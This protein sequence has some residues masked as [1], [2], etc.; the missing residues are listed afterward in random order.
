[1]CA[2]V[3]VVFAVIAE[4]LVPSVVAP[5]TVVAGAGVDG[6]IALT[7]VNDVVAWAGVDREGQ[8]DRS[9]D[10][11]EVINVVVPVARL[12]PIASLPAVPVTVRIPSSRTA[13]G[14]T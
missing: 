9:G 2:A 14:P 5:D 13:F 11:G 12:T 4:D 1:V 6:V 7:A 3:E 8:R 10:L